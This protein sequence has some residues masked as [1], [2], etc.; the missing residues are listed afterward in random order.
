MS[1][2]KHRLIRDHA[3]ARTM[4]VEPSLYADIMDRFNRRQD[5]DALVTI[6]TLF[7][8]NK[9]ELGRLFGVSRQA[10]GK[11]LSGG[12]TPPERVA[13][14]NRVAELARKLATIFKPDR[15]PSIVRAPLPGLRER[16]ILEVLPEEGVDQVY[17]L[18]ERLKSYVPAA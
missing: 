1:L 15:L 9:S 13:T 12:G 8:L 16:S 14:V 10:V 18:L 5:V 11:W 17:E 2:M 4:R 3:H 7:R 6:K